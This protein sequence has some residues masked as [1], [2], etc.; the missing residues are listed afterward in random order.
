V[1]ATVGNS[2]EVTKTTRTDNLCPLTAEML[3]AML[4]ASPVAV[5]ALDSAGIVTIW[6]PASER[7][8]GFSKE[9]VLGRKLPVLAVNMEDRVRILSTTRAGRSITDFEHR[10]M[11]RDGTIVLL[12]L[13]ASPLFNATQQITGS[14]YLA[15]D[16]TERRREAAALSEAKARAEEASRAKS[17]FLANMS[18]ELRTPMNGVLGMLDLILNTNVT[19]PHRDYLELA[20]SSAQSLMDMLNRILDVSQLEVG[21]LVLQSHSFDLGVPFSKARRP[22][23]RL[24]RTKRAWNSPAS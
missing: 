14:V 22:K 19:N 24:R 8:L 5:V 1:L 15:T 20:R 9:E 7:I 11:K 2:A 6:N 17:T 10:C 4:D 13:Y 23:R 18:H 16:V 12:N 21:N 3:A